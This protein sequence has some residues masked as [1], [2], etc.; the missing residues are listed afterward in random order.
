MSSFNLS[1]PI[2]IGADH[3]G[4]E[5]KTLEAFHRGP[6]NPETARTRLQGTLTGIAAPP[7]R[8]VWEWSADLPPKA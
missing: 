6:E 5:Y 4:F 7:K 2:A 3:A 8:G 1:L